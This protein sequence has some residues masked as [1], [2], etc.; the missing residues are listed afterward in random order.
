MLEHHQVSSFRLY[1]RSSDFNVWLL[2]VV[3]C[4]S[5]SVVRHLDF[6]V[7]YSEVETRNVTTG[8]AV[9]D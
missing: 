9:L 2:E 5:E 8:Y 4:Q 1:S 7:N 6:A 3:L